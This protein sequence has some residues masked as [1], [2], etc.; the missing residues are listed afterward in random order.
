MRF[1][2]TS[3][4]VP[5]LIEES[6]SAAMRELAATDPRLMVWWAT[7]I[8]AAAALARLEREGLSEAAGWSGL[9]RLAGFA[10]EWDLVP[11]S[12]EVKAAAIRM[13]RVHPLC[14]ADA[15]QLGAA[16]IAAQGSPRALEFVTLDARLAAAA[17]KEGF[18]LPAKPKSTGPA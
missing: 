10:E 15:L 12:D 18:P 5:L 9:S 16:V 1:W 3:A 7:E 14:A 11:A 13:A 4:L 8:E 17:R 2:D 6:E